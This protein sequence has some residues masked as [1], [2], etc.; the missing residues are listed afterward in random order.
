MSLLFN[1]YGILGINARNLEYL[2]PFNRRRAIKM[3][4]SKLKTK[5]FLAARDIPVP[6]LIATIRNLQEL[7]KFNFANLPESFVI[8]PN[9]GYGGEGIIVIENKITKNFWRKINGGAI[10]L[11]DLKEHL[12]DILDGR[13]SLASLPDLALFENRINSIEFIPDLKIAGLPDIRIIV[14]NLIPVMAMLRLP[15][16]KSEGK[17]N[18]HLGGLGLGIDLATGRTTHA[19]SENQILTKLPGDIPIQDHLIPNFF[20]I[21]KIAS[22]AQLHTNL[23]YLAA[24][25]AID[26]KDGPV[27]IEI[28][29]RAGLEVQVANLAPLKIR[30]ER[31]R[32]LKVTSPEHGV[33]LGCQLFGKPTKKKTLPKKSIIHYIEPGEILGKDKNHR[34]RVECSLAREISVIDQKLA[35]RIELSKINSD[36]AK[37]KILIGGQRLQTIAELQDLSQADYKVILGRRDLTNFLIEPTLEKTEEKVLPKIQNKPTLAIEDLYK[38]LD[39]TL[40]EIDRQV[41]L[42]AYLKPTNLLLERRRFFNST[43]I[44]PHFHYP[45]LKFDPKELYTSLAKLD[46]P[47]TPLG[48]IFQSKKNEIERKINLLVKIGTP[49]FF[50]A[51]KELYDFP[52][53]INLKSAQKILASQPKID[54]TSE[55]LIYDAESAQKKFTQI[56]Q[57]LGLTKWQVTIKDTLV[58]DAL[59]SK[60]RILFLRSGAMFSAERLA[61]LT[62]H[63]IETHAFRA[64]NGLLQPFKIF[65]RGFADYLETEEGLAVFQQNKVLSPTNPKRFWPAINLIAVQAAPELSFRGIFQLVQNFGCDKERAFQVALKI[66]RGLTDPTLPGGFTKEA[67]YFTGAQKIEK[68]VST[69]G[70]LKK[71]FIGKIKIS[72]LP[73][74]EKI[75]ELKPP[76][77]LPKYCRECDTQ[78]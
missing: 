44:E 71:L 17:A 40:F 4:D 43:K 25:L 59:A 15:T 42:L 51:S 24:D 13:F 37:L 30:L 32:G 10:A 48:Q 74:I 70:D 55:N 33:K 73:L 12:Q 9:A 16:V 76:K 54:Q 35:Q 65:N 66:K 77:F 63:E 68:F 2:R 64:E 53:K 34:V 49:E 28:N 3:A 27:L 38:Q 11:L 5:Q 72:D 23:G 67:V 69:G 47:E 41:K 45:K 46:F 36:S 8:K 1:D 52:N 61:A 75:P 18:I 58:A 14:H 22:Y 7:E 19:V 6:R 26:E 78:N 31:I 50:A 56:F 39:Q 29:A 62:A 20:E 57:E 60:S 21:L